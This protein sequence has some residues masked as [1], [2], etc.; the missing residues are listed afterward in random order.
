MTVTPEEL[1]KVRVEDP[2]AYKAKES[3][4]PK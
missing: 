4:F 3:G 2:K 1:K